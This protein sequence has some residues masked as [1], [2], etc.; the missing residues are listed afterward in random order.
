MCP[1]ASLVYVAVSLA[2][3]SLL[4]IGAMLSTTRRSEQRRFGRSACQS[5]ASA[6]RRRGDSRELVLA[7]RK[8]G[9]MPKDASSVILATFSR[10]AN[11]SFSPRTSERGKT[12]SRS[13]RE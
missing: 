10:E 5:L 4:T 1:I 8:P 6:F 11:S 2:I 9:E 3:S 13:E 7:R 12:F